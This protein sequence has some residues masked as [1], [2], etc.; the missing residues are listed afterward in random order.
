M[1]ECSIEQRLAHQRATAL[2]ANDDPAEVQARRDRRAGRRRKP[3]YASDDAGV[4]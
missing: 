4:G 1:E 3:H 2:A